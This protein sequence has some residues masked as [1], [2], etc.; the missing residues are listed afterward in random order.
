MIA[1]KLPICMKHK[2]LMKSCLSYQQIACFTIFHPRIKWGVF[3]AKLDNNCK[4][5]EIQNK[6]TRL[7][8]QSLLFLHQAGSWASTNPFTDF[9]FIFL[10]GNQEL[11]IT[12][13]LL[14]GS[15]LALAFIEDHIRKRR[16][17]VKIRLN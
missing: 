14:N 11:P 1:H 12:K 5:L 10:F 8:S 9:C 4:K 3:G 16:Y 7:R 6:R 17:Q 15:Q 2:Q 13:V